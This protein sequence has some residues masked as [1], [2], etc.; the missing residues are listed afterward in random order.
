LQ[1]IKILIGNGCPIESKSTAGWTVLIRAAFCGH[2]DIIMLLLSTGADI[3][4]CSEEGLTA[5]MIATQ[6]RF[7]C[8][9]DHFF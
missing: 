7:S 2:I 5:L 9:Y 4:A 1:I 6:V 8:D 3:N